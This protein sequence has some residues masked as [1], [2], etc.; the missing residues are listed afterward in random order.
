MRRQTLSLHEGYRSDPGTKAICVPIYQTS[1][2]HQGEIE[3]TSD[4]FNLKADGFTY[5]R[6]LNPTTRVFEKRYAKMDGG[7]D[8][9]ATA[10]GQAATTIAMLNICSSGDNI[11]SSPYLYGNTWN[12]FRHTFGRLGVEVRFVKDPRDPEQFRALTDKNTKAYFGEVLSNPTLVPLPVKRIAEIGAEYGIP[13]IVDNT[14]TTNVAFPL[15]HGAAIAV[16]SATKYMGG[17]GTTMGGL[18][19]D[20]GRFDWKKDADRFPLL[21]EVDPAHNNKYWHEAVE[22]LD[23]LG[24][25]SYLLKGRMTW[26]RD[27]GACISPFNS[28]LLIQGVETLPLRMERH[29][30]NALEVAAYLKQHKKVERVVYPKYY[31]GR[32]KEI[33]DDMFE[34]GYGAIVYFDLKGGLEAGKKFIQ[35]LNL[36]YHVANV[37]D[38]RSLATHPASTTHT[39]VPEDKRIEDGINNGSIRICVGIENIEDI[40]QDIEQAM[41]AT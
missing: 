32:D 15:E 17:H 38:A 25:S 16:Y 33:I 1:A 3:T 31:Q 7:V 27:L 9:L 26:M 23:D 28:F 22:S 11:V 24:K 18:I 14:I 12:L 37:G 4:I 35:N 8:A 10:S 36:L 30:K 6:I 2:F 19:V 5:T 41:E 20:G 29:C 13:L 21:N 34:T 40:L 39:T